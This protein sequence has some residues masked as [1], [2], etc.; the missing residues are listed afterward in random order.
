MGSL[1]QLVKNLR[2]LQ[3]LWETESCIHQNLFKFC[4]EQIKRK[5]LSL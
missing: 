4:K 3:N 1:F 2:N 5:K